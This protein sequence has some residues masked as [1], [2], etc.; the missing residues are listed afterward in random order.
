M[1]GLG[2][3]SEAVLG[4]AQAVAG[5]TLASTAPASLSAVLGPGVVFQQ[6]QLEATP[7]STLP[8]DSH[9]VVKEGHLLDA[10]TLTFT[11]PAAAGYAQNFLVEV[12]YQDADVGATVLPYYNAANPQ[13]GFS[14]PGGAGT[15]Q[16]T[17]RRGAVAYQ[18]KAGVAATA[19]TQTSPAPDAGWAGIYVVTLAQGATSITAGNITPYA[20]APFIPVTLP[21]VPLGVQSGAWIFASATG[22][23]A[24]TAGLSPAPATLTTGMEIV[25]WLGLGVSNT[26]PGTLN[27]NARG[28]TP[29]LRQGGGA[30]ASGD[31][32]TF[33]PLIYDGANW[34]VNGPVSSDV[35]GRL[36]GAPRY[37]TSS[38]TYTPTPGMKTCIVEAI[39]GGGS[40]AGATLPS[41]GYV[42]LGAG[43]TAG[44]YAMASYTAAQ[45]GAS[46]AVT[47]GAGAPSQVGGGGLSGG[48]TYFGSLLTCPGGTG[49]LMLNGVGAPTQNGN[50]TDSPVATGTGI[51]RQT[52]GSITALSLATSVSSGSGGPGGQSPFGPGGYG[53][54]T[55]ASG[56]AAPPGNYGSGGGGCVINN[57]GGGNYSGG[58]AA[59]GVVIVWEYA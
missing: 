59:P 35:T 12:Q 36:L 39:G 41:A 6:A 28:V 31:L 54:S 46:Q 56:S 26:G 15:A 9:T 18:I 51:L 7:F 37:F 22:T 27:L 20:G 29:I 8:T 55:N 33:A 32:N 50:G 49:P 10:Q 23:N 40:G 47:I 34:R 24:Y 5:F 16:N 19:G 17:V 52:I 4:T 43:G 58:A 38:G 53:V 57:G 48:V 44:T 21:G 3:L 1:V 11:P 30:L 14:G 42:S 45:V 2:K 25:L 13:V